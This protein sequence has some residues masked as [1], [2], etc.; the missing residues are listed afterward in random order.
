MIRCGIFNHIVYATVPESVSVLQMH[1]MIN[2]YI[3][4]LLFSHS[5]RES[6]RIFW[7]MVWM[8]INEAF[9]LFSLAPYEYREH[10][11]NAYTHCLRIIIGH[12]S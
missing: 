3:Y 6:H 4:Y 12:Y 8:L 10:I 9:I 7:G 1:I 5:Q 11:T 2:F